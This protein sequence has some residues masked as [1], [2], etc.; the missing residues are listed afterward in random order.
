MRTPSTREGHLPSSDAIRCSREVVEMN[1]EKIILAIDR[2]AATKEL[3]SVVVATSAV[4]L[5]L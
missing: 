1:T 2:D 4:R 5:A 3:V